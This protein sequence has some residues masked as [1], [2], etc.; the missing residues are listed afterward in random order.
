MATDTIFSDP[1]VQFLQR[2]LESVLKGEIA[3]PR[4]Q[5]PFVWDKERRL[6]L[7]DS[8]R[9]GIPI[10][11]LMIWE[12]RAPGPDGTE[13]VF[14]KT[15]L[16]PFELPKVPTSATRRYLLDG[17]QRL[18]TLFFALHTPREAPEPKGEEPP[19]AFEAYYDLE[20]ETFEVR[21]DLTEPLA[22]PTRHFPLRRIFENRGVLRFQRDMEAAIA[23][24]INDSEA[25]D[26]KVQTFTE[27]SDAIAEAFRQYKIPVTVMATDDLTLTTETFKRVNSQGVSM[28]EAHMMNAISWQSS[29]ELL[30]RFDELRED[31]GDERYWSSRDNL[32]DDVLLR[33]SKRLLDVDVYDENVSEIAPKLRSGDVL[34]RVG[35]SMKR[36][37]RFLTDRGLRN[38]AHMPNIMQL[39]VLGVVFDAVPTPSD[40]ALDRLEDWLWFVSYSEVFSRVVRGSTYK[41]LERQA[42]SLA[43]GL[44][45]EAPPRR[46]VRKPIPRF[47]FR[48]A[49]SR[50]LSW[51]FA[52]NMMPFDGGK[53]AD[54]LALGGNEAMVRI[55]S[56][57]RGRSDLASSPAVRVLCD[58]DHIKN[59]RGTERYGQ[60][61]EKQRG[62]L[63]LTDDAIDA[64]RLGPERDVPRFVELREKALNDLEQHRFD[65]I[66]DTLFRD[67]T[68]AALDD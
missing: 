57:P 45:P 18:M 61:D 49:R 50:A 4:F 40:A 1:S 11:S 26:K 6:Q 52:R 58:P 21:E 68:P 66:Y 56:A 47:D 7:F 24:E 27:R 42:L 65:E 31:F 67:A 33:V 14:P 59:L 20:A 9:R 54:A 22:S 37:A 64:L 35:R 23:K 51:M 60:F 30:K 38:P 53:A 34:E 3:L 32:E 55:T 48:S 13:Q 5:R 41:H 43:R 2:L 29:F 28:S 44:S 25:F 19:A 46:V 16:G 12:T 63:V 39:V 17:E 62:A 8:V 10:G 36:C 15:E